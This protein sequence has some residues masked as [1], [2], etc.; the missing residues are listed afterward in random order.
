VVIETFEPTAVYRKEADG[1]YFVF[2]PQVKGV[3]SEGDTLKEARVMIKEALEGIIEVVLEK[4]LQNYFTPND[5]KKI[6]GDIEERINIEKKLQIA[7]S[8]KIAR[9]RAGLT[10][11]E[12]AHRLGVR[13]HYISRY[14]K[15]VVIPSVDRFLKLFE[16]LLPA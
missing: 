1:G 12:L 6:P 16:A 2:C 14:E 3:F 13:R 10:Q 11:D 5:E 8:I 9:E 7:V 15:G 4:D